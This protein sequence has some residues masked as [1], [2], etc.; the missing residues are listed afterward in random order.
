M[1]LVHTA[2]VPA[3]LILDLVSQVGSSKQGRACRLRSSLGARTELCRM[4]GGAHTEPSLHGEVGT[5]LGSS[6]CSCLDPGTQPWLCL[7]LPSPGIPNCTV[8]SKKPG[9]GEDRGVDS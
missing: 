4:G 5:Q 1:S 2:P 3:G 6:W 9:P 7:S 8:E